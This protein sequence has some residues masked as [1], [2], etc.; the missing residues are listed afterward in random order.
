M[1]TIPPLKKANYSQRMMLLATLP[2]V[3]I[4]VFSLAVLHLKAVWKLPPQTK[5]LA[6]SR[7]IAR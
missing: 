3:L 2:V 4:S 5:R 1:K 6:I 7:L